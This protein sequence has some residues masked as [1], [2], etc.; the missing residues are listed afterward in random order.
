ML[1]GLGLLPDRVRITDV[2]KVVEADASNRL[3]VLPEGVARRVDNWSEVV[4]CCQDHWERY[5][6]VTLDCRRIRVC[7]CY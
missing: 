7:A 2:T 6:C 5:E 4:Y 3:C 1:S